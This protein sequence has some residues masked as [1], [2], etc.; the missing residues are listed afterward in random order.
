DMFDVQSSK[1][2]TALDQYKENIPYNV[3]YKLDEPG[4]HYANIM[5]WSQDKNEEGKFTTIAYYTVKGITSYAKKDLVIETP[6]LDED[7]VVLEEGKTLKNPFVL[8]EREGKVL[9]DVQ[10]EYEI[11]PAGG[12][13][14]EADGTIEVQQKGCTRV[15]VKLKEDQIMPGGVT[16]TI[17]IYVP[18]ADDHHCGDNLTWSFDASTGVLHISGYGDMYNYKQ[19]AA[20]WTS[21]RDSICS[22]VIDNG[23]TSIGN[24]AFYGLSNKNLKTIDLP[25]SV[26]QIGQYAFANCKYLKN[27]YLGASLEEI[28]ANAFANDERLIYITCYAIEPPLLDESAFVNY[29]AYLSVP[30]ESQADYKVS[31][32]WKLFNKE[33][34][35]CIGAEEKPIEEDSVI[36]DPQDNQATITW[37][38]NDQAAGYSIE[39]TK[40]GVVFCTL[41]FNAQGQ[42]IGIAFAPSRDGA[43]ETAAATMTANGWQF[44]VTGLNQGSKYNYT[45]D[46]LNAQQQS[47]KQ[48]TGEF[49][50]TGGIITNLYS[51]PNEGK[52][53][54]N[55]KFIIHNRLLIFR[56]GNFFNALG[57]R[58]K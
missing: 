48:Y 9:T 31:K 43:R 7:T 34:I 21:F 4:I 13:Q 58:M 24:Y 49:I 27:L 18:N 30:C 46:V 12:V 56:H 6:S 19:G 32:G 38:Q 37:P 42:L 54:H 8:K 40:D 28:Y 39:I 2:P 51:L 50:T 26:K 47:I 52:D 3:Q 14:I 33:N 55:S 57:D 17:W 5:F 11:T 45:L 44:T 41:K 22:L 23:C 10:Y 1:I 25:N 16:D 20:P 15:V 35:S 36:V 53:A 29:D